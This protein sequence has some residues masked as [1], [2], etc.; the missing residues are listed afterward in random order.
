MIVAER[1]WAKVDKSGECWEWT[2]CLGGGGYGQIGLNQKTVYS[3]RLS[4]VLHHPLTIDLWEHKDILVC[5][6]CDNRKCVNPAHLFLG[7]SEDNSKDMVSKGRGKPSMLKGEK[8]GMVKLTETQV[9][10]IRGRYANGNITQ[11]AL[12]DEYE[13]N[14]TA[15]NKIVRRLNWTHI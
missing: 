7:S 4:Y 2:G 11:K 13:V 5:H 14:I 1:F 3:H 15:I 9:R 10:E 8:H 6:K 12:S